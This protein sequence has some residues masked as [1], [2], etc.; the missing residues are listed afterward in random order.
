LVDGGQAKRPDCG[1]DLDLWPQSS[2]AGHNRRM[3]Q[4]VNRV[5]GRI[6]GIAASGVVRVELK[7]AT[8]RAPVMLSRN[9]RSS[10]R[11]CGASDTIFRSMS[12][13]IRRITRCARLKAV[14]PL[15]TRVNGFV[16][17]VL[18]AARAFT[19]YQSFSTSAG[20]GK[21]KRC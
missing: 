1:L 2:L 9:L 3:G 10:L 12:S 15:N 4:I 21:S 20:L 6:A 11:E 5:F 17:A 13:D 18:I 7:P 16:S 14:P 19:T 8:N